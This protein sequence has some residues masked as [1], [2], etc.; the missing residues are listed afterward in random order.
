[1]VILNS[2]MLGKRWVSE[3]YIRAQEKSIQKTFWNLLTV[4]FMFNSDLYTNLHFSFASSLPPL[5]HSFL[6]SIKSGII[7]VCEIKPA[8][9][10]EGTRSEDGQPVNYSQTPT[11]SPFW[12]SC[13][14]G[15][16]VRAP[17][18]ATDTLRII[19]SQKWILIKKCFNSS[20]GMPHYQEDRWSNPTLAISIRLSS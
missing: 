2:R 20:Q 18:P 3:W 4:K 13:R 8:A 9:A 1:M 17:H 14:A 7:P 19:L 10:P 5:P 12:P 11:G 6:L 16:C 15:Q